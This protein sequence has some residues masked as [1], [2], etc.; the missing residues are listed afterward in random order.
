[1]YQIPVYIFIDHEQQNVTSKAVRV[2]Y[3]SSIFLRNTH[4]DTP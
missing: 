3:D 4:N 2:R 1:M